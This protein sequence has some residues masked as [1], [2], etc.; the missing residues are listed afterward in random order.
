MPHQCVRCGTFYDDGS[1]DIISGC[2]CG[3][4]LFFFVKNKDKV[5]VKEENKLTKK[6]KQQME[7]DIYDLL[8]V[9]ANQEK[10]IFLDVESINV[11]KP[12]KYRLDLVNL[13]KKQPLVYKLDDGKYM[14]DLPDLFKKKGKD[15]L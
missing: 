5:K 1:K 11:I 12:G 3:G 13:L 4:K 10:P 6:E 15:A 2:S 7:D 9:E 14:I 8:G